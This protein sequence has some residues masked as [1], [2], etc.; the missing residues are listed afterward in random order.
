M[1][2]YRT[3]ERE[4]HESNYMF[5]IYRSHGIALVRRN[6]MIRYILGVDLG[7]CSSWDLLD[8]LYVGEDL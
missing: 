6:G 2:R 8:V 7:I 5:V 1:I 3:R 4:M